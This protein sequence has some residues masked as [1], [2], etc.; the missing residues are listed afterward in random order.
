LNK[1]WDRY[2]AVSIASTGTAIAAWLV[3]R[4]AIKSESIDGEARNLVLAKDVLLTAAATTGLAS[5]V[6]RSLR[7]SRQARKAPRP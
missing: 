6:V 2:N 4:G 1:A 7:F 5:S 3:G